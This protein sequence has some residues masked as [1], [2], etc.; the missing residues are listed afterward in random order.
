MQ[1]KIVDLATLARGAVS[2]KFEY[3][4]QKI[5]RNILDPNTDPTKARSLTLKI[6]FKPDF[7]RESTMV[8]VNATSSLAPEMPVTTALYIE[9]RNGMVSA[10]E[11]SPYEQGE[12]LPNR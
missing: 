3:E 6:T 4:L 5:L 10:S 1:E 8:Q 7:N 2:E 11:Y 12:L 9:E